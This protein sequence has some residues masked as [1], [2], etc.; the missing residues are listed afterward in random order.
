MSLVKE[1]VKDLKDCKFFNE[2][3][4]FNYYLVN[5]IIYRNLYNLCQNSHTKAFSN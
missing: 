1:K 2:K 5:R 3:L 4:L